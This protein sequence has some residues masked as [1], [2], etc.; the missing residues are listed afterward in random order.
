MSVLNSVQ[1][2]L[3]KAE[4]PLHYKEITERLL[5]SGLWTSAGRTPAAT[6]NAQLAVDIKKHGETSAFRR[7][8]RGVFMLN[9][10]AEQQNR[11]GKPHSDHLVAE[12]SRQPN[13]CSFTDA[14]ERILKVWQ[15]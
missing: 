7:A 9:N 13:P 8:G 6:V 12:R 15:R 3:A 11:Q 5:H 14:A 2:V 10:S 4:C 1:I